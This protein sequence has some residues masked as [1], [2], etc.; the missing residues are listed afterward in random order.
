[1][2]TARLL[3]NQEKQAGEN[4]LPPPPRTHMP[5]LTNTH[6][7]T[8]HAAPAQLHHVLLQRGVG[9]EAQRRQVGHLLGAL[10]KLA[11]QVVPPS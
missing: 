9:L 4:A 8:A 1:M 2:G 5:T 11:P 10:L 3:Y 6:A 7:H